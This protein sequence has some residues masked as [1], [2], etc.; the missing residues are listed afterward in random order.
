MR[1]LPRPVRAWPEKP[2][3]TEEC[4]HAASGNAFPIFRCD[5]ASYQAWQ[6]AEPRRADKAFTHPAISTS[7]DYVTHPSGFA[8]TGA[9]SASHGAYSDLT[10]AAPLLSQTKRSG[11]R[12]RQCNYMPQPQRQHQYLR[13][14]RRITPPRLNAICPPWR[15]LL[16]P[17]LAF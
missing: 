11:G 13:N 3:R 5:A 12:Q 17:P 1:R 16:L 15:H 8:S 9:L 2:D 7:R 4:V 10:L 14:M 6:N